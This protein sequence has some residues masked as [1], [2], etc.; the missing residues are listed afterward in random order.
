MFAVTSMSSAYKDIPAWRLES[1]HIGLLT[2]YLECGKR[3]SKVN[4]WSRD[5]ERHVYPVQHEQPS[6]EAYWEVISNLVT[7]WLLS[8]RSA[9]NSNKMRVEFPMS[10]CRIWDGPFSCFS[11]SLEV[12]RPPKNYRTDPQKIPSF[13]LNSKTVHRTRNRTRLVPRN[14]LINT[15][16]R[17]LSSPLESR[18]DLP[19]L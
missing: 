11:A 1:G 9:I 14:R 13:P 5:R 12:R 18:W 3:V 10:P 17:P 8:D 7:F 2:L 15:S 16:V 6:H 19:L 4:F